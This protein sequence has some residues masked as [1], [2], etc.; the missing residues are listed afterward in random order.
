V[1]LSGSVAQ[2]YL[3]TSGGSSFALQMPRGADVSQL[4]AS[5]GRPVRTT[6]R[7]QQHQGGE[8]QEEQHQG[9]GVVNVTTAGR[10][11][12]QRTLVLEELPVQIPSS[13]SRRLLAGPDKPAPTGAVSIIVFIMDLSACGT[14]PAA[15]PQV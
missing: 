14:P 11:G 1:G 10:A 5:L 9:E 6:F 2:F 4:S 3:R 8:Q 7:E 13:A 15:T 12:G